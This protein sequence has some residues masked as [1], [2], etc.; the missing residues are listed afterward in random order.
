M[1]LVVFWA[2]V[3]VDVYLVFLLLRKACIA[4]VAWWRKRRME[5]L[6]A[7]NEAFHQGQK[8]V[9]GPY[10]AHTYRVRL[11]TPDRPGPRRYWEGKTVDEICAELEGRV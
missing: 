9:M 5:H 10:I 4:Y 1:E 11:A 2:I 7:L 8:S 3:A 6:R